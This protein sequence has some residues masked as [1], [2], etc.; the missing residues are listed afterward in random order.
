[1]AGQEA[2]HEPEFLDL[3]P[4]TLFVGQTL[5]TV[6][7]TVD[8]QTFNRDDGTRDVVGRLVVA[9]APIGS[10]ASV[11]PPKA[12]SRYGLVSACNYKG[13]RGFELNSWKDDPAGGKDAK[14]R[15]K[16]IP[17]HSQLASEL[18][19]LF[20]CLLSAGMP[21]GQP[22]QD[23][24]RWKH[25][26]E[27]AMLAAAEA[28]ADWDAYEAQGWT[29]DMITAQLLCLAVNKQPCRLVCKTRTVTSATYF[30]QKTG[31]E[32]PARDRLTFGSWQDATDDNLKA[33]HLAVWEG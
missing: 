28:G 24:A 20:N 30:N 19:G 23:A 25:T 33:K 1:M 22:E 13:F 8:V 29:P 6:P 5:P 11:A 32:V 26:T 14:G 21:K 4:N 31:E 12:G 10:V 16:R 15:Q 9:V 18:K 2:P 17:D 27:L 7:L 3:E